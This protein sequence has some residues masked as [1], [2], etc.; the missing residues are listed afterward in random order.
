MLLKNEESIHI[1]LDSKINS[2]IAEYVP[3]KLINY[4]TMANFHLRQ[5][6]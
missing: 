3:Y 4:L 2:T 6:V 1:A 5:I